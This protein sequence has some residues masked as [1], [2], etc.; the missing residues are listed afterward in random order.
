MELIMKSYQEMIK[1]HVDQVYNG[2]LRHYEWPSIRAISHT[3]GI[4]EGQ[5]YVDIAEEKEYHQDIVKEK[6]KEENRR[7]NEE[8]RLANLEKISK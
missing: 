8:R 3:F 6:R 2:E 7:K 1:W 4:D 5:V